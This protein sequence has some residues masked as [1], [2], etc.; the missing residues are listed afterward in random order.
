MAD[1]KREPTAAEAMLFFSIVK[2]TRNKAD[3]DWNA[4]ATEAGFK[5]ADVAKV[6]F[7][8]VKRKLGISTETTAAPRAPA[9]PRKT[10][11]GR[12]SKTTTPR[13][14]VKGKGKN[15]KVKKEEES[16]DIFDDD[17][18]MPKPSVKDEDHDSEK[19]PEKKSDDQHS[20]GNFDDTDIAYP[21]FQ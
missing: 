10:A 7:G 2:H 18:E 5:N 17:E 8:Q 21:F 3:V 13:S 15:N 4:V 20:F 16:F 11:G 9:T 19:T 12:V 6:R 14:T 1:N